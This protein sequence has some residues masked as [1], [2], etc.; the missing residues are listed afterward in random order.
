MNDGQS[1]KFG[2]RVPTQLALCRNCLRFVQPHEV[3]CPFCQQ[4]LLISALEYQV[5]LI[6][7]QEAADHLAALLKAQP[8]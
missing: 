4:N 3:D 1:A 5:K 7:A 2:G 6:E 8:T